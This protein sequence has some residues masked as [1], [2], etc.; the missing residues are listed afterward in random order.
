MTRRQLVAGLDAAIEHCS[1]QRVALH[2]AERA[3]VQARET[4]ERFDAEARR[5]EPPV[6]GH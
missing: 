3:M 2:L 6:H 5:P 1:K 4:L